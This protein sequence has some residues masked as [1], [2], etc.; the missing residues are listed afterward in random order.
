MSIEFTNGFSITQ[1]GNIPPGVGNY[2]LVAAYRPANNQGEITIP[3]HD[4]TTFSLDFNDV[5]E[6]T[7]NAIYINKY[8]SNGNDNSTYL[9]QLIGNHTHLSF[10]Q[11]NYHITF[12]C[13]S[14][15]WETNNGGY[16]NQVLHDPS[17]ENAPQNSISIISTSG[18]AYNTNDPVEISIQII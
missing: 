12:D 1:G 14:T 3:K 4:N 9:N 7:G 6:N 16:V 2:Y 8:D 15:A 13:L 17:F 10:S 11:N 5:N 18:T